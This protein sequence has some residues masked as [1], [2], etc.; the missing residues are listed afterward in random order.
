MYAE[1]ARQI[2]IPIRPTR[3]GKIKV[4]IDVYTAFSTL[5]GTH[6][7]SVTVSSDFLCH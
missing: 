5:R 6:I 3:V 1:L 7:V 4:H 2:S